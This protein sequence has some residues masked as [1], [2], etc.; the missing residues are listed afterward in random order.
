MK[1][2]LWCTIVFQFA[3]STLLRNV[4]VPLLFHSNYI[5]RLMSSLISLPFACL[6]LACGAVVDEKDKGDL[7][8]ISDAPSADTPAGPDETRNQQAEIEGPR[9]FVDAE[10]GEVL[11]DPIPVTM[12]EFDGGHDFLKMSRRLRVWRSSVQFD[13]TVDAEGHATDCEVVDQF[14]K[15][16]VNM[17]LCEVVMNHTTFTPARDD[18]NQPVEG[19]YRHS[20][21]YADLRAEL[22]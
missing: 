8:A 14:R 7:A 20:L 17:K 6:A 11:I 3:L 1:I 10:T 13:M 16:Y 5:G 22:D 18:H 9:I 2:A 12:V 15:T 4:H 21:S 19:S